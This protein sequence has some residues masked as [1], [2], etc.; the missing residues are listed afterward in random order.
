VC[1]EDNNNASIKFANDC[2]KKVISGT[3]T[4]LK[5]DDEFITDKEK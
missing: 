5:K 3:N 2:D 4:A 1:K